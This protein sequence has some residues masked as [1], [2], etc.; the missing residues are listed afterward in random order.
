VNRAFCQPHRAECNLT[1]GE[2]A[3][4]I[5]SK[6]FACKR[7][8][9]ENADGIAVAWA[10]PPY[11][12]PVQQGARCYSCVEGD[13]AVGIIAYWVPFTYSVPLAYWALGGAI[14]GAAL[15]A[16]ISRGMA[17]A[18]S[19]IAEELKAIPEVQKVYA[20]GYEIWL[21]C[22]PRYSRYQQWVLEVRKRGRGKAHLSADLIVA[23]QCLYIANVCVDPGH[24]NQ[25]LAT[26]MLLCA[27]R[28]TQCRALTTSGRTSHGARFFEK[29]RSR[30]SHYGVELRDHAAI[31]AR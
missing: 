31:W 24:G 17:S 20:E 26:A 1:T 18:M 19:P 11:L 30:L 5:L 3:D 10:S 13:I 7:L 29:N 6:S 8:G 15:I 12:A 4:K 27:A 16:V 9:F 14:G 28:L 2:P 21:Y 22:S 25:G 23:T